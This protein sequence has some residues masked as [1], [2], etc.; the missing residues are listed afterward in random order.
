MA[1]VLISDKLSPAAVAIFKQRGIEA[2]VKTGL[3]KEELIAIIGEYD[4]LAIRSATKVTADVLKAAKNL[5][6]VG[7]AGIGVDNV[8]IPAATAAGVIVM[9]TPFGNSITTAEHAIAMMMAL[10]RDIPAANAST[11]AGK[12]EKNRFMGVELYGKILGLIGAGNIGSIVADRARG[13]KMHVVAYDPYL[14]VERASELGVEKVELNELLSRADFI[15][16]HTPL[17]AETRNI[18]SADALQK[19]KKGVRIINCARGGLVDELALKAALESG[20]VAGAAL[21][22][23]EEEPA[24]SNA[25]FGSEKLIATPHLGAS[26]V[27][28]Q[29]NVALQ[30]AEQISDYILTGAIVN[31]LN[32]PS[33]SAEEAQ[34]VRPWISLAEKLGAFVGQLTGTSI[35]SLDL[36]YEGIAAELNLR[37]LTQAA[38]MGLLH[39]TLSE[40][41]MVNAP[42]V[43]KERG[44]T[45]SETRRPRQ[46][47]YEGYIK[48]TANLADGSTRRVAG[49]VFAD[50]RP[51][52]IQA[53]DINMDA[54]FAPHML[55]VINEDKPG[56]IGKLGT[57]LGE[58]G[59]NIAN[60]NLGRSAPGADAI[61][62]VE[63][64]GRLDGKVLA[65][66][67]KL[68]L[69][70]DA[71]A[72]AF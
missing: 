69:V 24:K 29:E 62:L 35:H 42:L 71:K 36:L 14:S 3:S 64:D 43:A 58:S 22:V 41:N 13:L 31:A 44:I 47:V 20:H 49:T 40:V 55:Y 19:T 10:A 4:G 18:L 57:L 23:F 5:K 59:V 63:V 68:P 11:Q 8:D 17:T 50:G 32:M 54:E 52:L 12:W 56:F 2:D 67:A 9:N 1:K 60:F 53:K 48:V 66:I 38:V 37:A 7:R 30:V 6:V 65:A 26:T 21:D 45:V 33:I 61:A 72:L 15:T 28:A 25:L 70:K 39:P 27:E 51:R 34:K 46:G 16:L